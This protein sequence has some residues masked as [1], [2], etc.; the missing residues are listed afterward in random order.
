MVGGEDGA[1]T[2]FNIEGLEPILSISAHT[3]P[4]EMLYESPFIGDIITGSKYNLVKIF[5]VDNGVL[6]KYWKDIKI[7]Y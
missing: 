6:L 7:Q 2:V 3:E 4:L 5:K 1:V